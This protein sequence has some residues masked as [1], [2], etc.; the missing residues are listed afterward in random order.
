MASLYGHVT[1]K[2]KKKKKKHLLE[3]CLAVIQPASSDK[4][5]GAD[6]GRPHIT[7]E[8]L[9]MTLYSSH[10]QAGEVVTQRVLQQLP[11]GV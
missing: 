2:W 11:A 1:V 9:L 10:S 3:G 7:Q 8:Q 4:E 5:T 6:S